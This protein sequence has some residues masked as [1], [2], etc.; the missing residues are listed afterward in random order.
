MV[1]NPQNIES[2]MKGKLGV[3]E[4]PNEI[5]ESTKTIQ[6]PLRQAVK[7][8]KDQKEYRSGKIGIVIESVA[9]FAHRPYSNSP[10]VEK[11]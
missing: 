5:F 1:K 2:Q 9:V 6:T 7:H 3:K 11:K 4:N 10:R 8:P